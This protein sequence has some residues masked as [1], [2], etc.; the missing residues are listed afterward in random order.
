M[1]GVSTCVTVGV[2][3]MVGIGLEETGAKEDTE[4]GTSETKIAHHY[5]INMA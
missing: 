4:E 3:I 2:D 5:Q 1:G